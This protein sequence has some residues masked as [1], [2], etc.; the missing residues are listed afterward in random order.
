MLNFNTYQSE[1]LSLRME[2]A[3]PEYCLHGLSG[4]AGE[5][6]S[7]RAKGIRDGLPW[8]YDQKMKKELGDV[9]W[10]IAAIA[11]DHGFTLE[12]IARANLLKL[13]SRKANNTLGG[14]G[15]DR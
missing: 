9:L 12:D 11:A 10:F 4:E 5:V 14:S 7:L 3:T 8:D 2:T 15:D 13:F 6:A 1:A